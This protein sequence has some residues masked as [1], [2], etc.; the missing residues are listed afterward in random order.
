MRSEGLLRKSTA[1]GTDHQK[2]YGD[3]EFSS[4][5]NFSSLI[6]PLQEYFFRMR[7]L[8]SG[9]LAVHEFFHSV[10]PCMNFL[11]T[12][13]P[14]P[15]SITFLMVLR[16]SWPCRWFEMVRLRMLNIPLVSYS[17]LAFP[18]VKAHSAQIAHMIG[19]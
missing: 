19:G 12:S 1:L 13:T 9:L 15:P 2:S 7:E 10:F 4:C 16:L 8:F 6:F 17:Q 14:P 5:T 11:C 3:G 18:E